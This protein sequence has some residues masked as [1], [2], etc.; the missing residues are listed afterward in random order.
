MKCDCDVPGARPE[1]S[2]DAANDL[3]K[4]AASNE[5]ESPSDHEVEAVSDQVE[6][7]VY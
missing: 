7:C 4:D 1:R 2:A 5:A 3:V 6:D